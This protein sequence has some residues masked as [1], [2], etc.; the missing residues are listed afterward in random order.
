VSAPTVALDFNAESLAAVGFP[1]L[2]RRFLL[3]RTFP[4]RRPG[5]KSVKSPCAP[6]GYAVTGLDE[7]RWI[8]FERAAALG[9]RHGWGL[10][11]ALGWGVCGLD[12]DGCRGADGTLTEQ[13][14]RL[15][16]YFPT[17][18]ERSPSGTGVKA[19]FLAG[20]AFCRTAKNDAHRVELYAGRRFFAL[21]GAPLEGPRSL[22]DC[23]AAACA[24][25]DVLRLP[26]RAPTYRRPA[27]QL[28]SDV[29][30][31]LERSEV[32][33]EAPSLHGGSIYTLRRC[34]FTGEEHRGG[35]PFAVSFPDGRL[36]LR[37][38]RS[39]HGPLTKMFRG[40]SS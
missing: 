29:R 13:A 9:K 3:W 28:G 21:T 22:A 14:R 12:L 32:V 15:L 1:A 11:V 25:A 19:Y 23:T 33:R 24:L 26:P 30:G 18:V 40:G 39:S 2:G 10:G 37:C 34:P 4:P 16:R 38:D 31:V 35:G 6:H 27:R 5:G 8:D 36:H 17:Y 7:R 20:P